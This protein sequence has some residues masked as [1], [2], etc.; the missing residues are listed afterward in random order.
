MKRMNDDPAVADAN[1]CFRQRRQRV[2]DCVALKQPD[3]L[4]VGLFTLFWLARYGNISYRDLMYDH[5]KAQEIALRACEE[6]DP[7][8]FDC[9][10]TMGTGP[11][12][13]QCEFKQL[14][15]PGHGVDDN[16]P[17]Q[18]LDKEYML[19]EEYDDFLLDPTG[20]Y[21]E[22]YLPR[23]M[24]AYDG[25]QPLG[26]V[27]GDFFIPLAYSSAMF[28]TPPVQAALRRLLKS[29]EVAMDSIRNEV[30]FSQHLAGAGVPMNVGA[31]MLAPYDFVA[32][33]FRGATGAMK[34]TFRHQ[35][36]LLEMMDKVCSLQLRRVLSRP[37][38]QGS[39]QVFIP[40][41][42][43]AG[44][45]MS[46]KAFETFFWPP[47]R[48]MLISLIDSGRV[49]LV[50]WEH[51]CTKRWDTIMDIPGGKCIYWFEHGDLVKAWQTMGD[52]VCLKGNVRTT[53]LATGTPD[54][55]DAE[56]RHLVD[57]IW[58]KGGS[59]IL[60]TAL[61]IPDE[62]PVPNVRAFFDAARRYGS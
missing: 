40:I 24:G 39:N 45:F 25:L 11:L 16:R 30:A 14:E 22:K 56:V 57:N 48:K 28:A 38:L 53:T 13:E 1:P 10:G 18:Y 5:D 51:D 23:V 8:Y 37:M 50:F 36:K 52:V 15:W 29:G 12:L 33:F 20:F 34:D 44:A 31:G 43:A 58:N 59:F 32:D 26:A 42:W 55:V 17:Y 35:D 7:D 49:P 4:P 27:A 6:F 61:G 62:T 2:L 21:F 41:H 9:I 47:L 54:M 3:R 60:E 19:A 46:P